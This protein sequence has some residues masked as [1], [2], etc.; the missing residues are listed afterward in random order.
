MLNGLH[1]NCWYY[2]GGG[3]SA[4]DRSARG[5]RSWRA[6]DF[7]FVA[8]MRAELGGGACKLMDVPIAFG[9]AVTTV[10]NL[11]A[12]LDRYHIGRF[13]HSLT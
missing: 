9:D 6:G 10:R 7:D 2:V 1:S 3:C 11:Q 12:P 4:L 5:S 13:A 8:D